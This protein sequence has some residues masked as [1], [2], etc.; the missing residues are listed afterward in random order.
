MQRVITRREV[1]RRGGATPRRA[2]GH[3][4]KPLPS[5]LRQRLEYALGTDLSAVRVHIGPSAAGLARMQ[6]ARALAWGNDIF[7]APQQFDLNSPPGRLRLA[8][9]IVHSVQQRDGTRQAAGEGSSQVVEQEA[10]QGANAVLAGRR[11]QVRQR[12]ARQIQRDDSDVPEVRPFSTRPEFQL[13]LDPEVQQTLLRMHIRRWMAGL[14]VNGSPPADTA[15]QSGA[16]AGDEAAGGAP[17]QADAGTQPVAA[18]GPVTGSG[19]P[20]QAGGG[21]STAR[22]PGFL[23]SPPAADSLSPG[24]DVGAL[25]SPFHVRQASAGVRDVDEVMRIYRRNYRFVSQLP[26][27]RSAVPGFLRFLVPTDWRQGLAESFTSAAVDTQLQH[28]FPTFTEVSDQFFFTVT[29][30]KTTYL[31]SLTVYSF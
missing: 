26:D 9:E 21:D 6:G 12:V 2:P 15:T 27:L 31:P 24:P 18:S 25:L 10:W 1:R 13:Q 16:G 23:A 8:H 17:T 30:T 29:G 22:P 7:F 19:G 5:Q 28:D 3:S 4:G 11:F 14:W 20:P